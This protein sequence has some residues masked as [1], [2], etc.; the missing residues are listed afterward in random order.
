MI[1]EKD[2]KI[3]NLLWKNRRTMAWIALISIMIVTILCFFVVSVE[4]LDKL[5]SVVT[6]FYTTMASVVGAYM[7]L[8]T[9]ASIKGASPYVNSSVDDTGYVEDQ[10]P[11]P[12]LKKPQLKKP[13]GPQKS[14]K[15]LRSFE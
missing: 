4:R 2:I 14:K 5:S 10:V 7:G 8:S 9:Y 1:E 11:T 12:Q 3:D 13:Q 6:W 15:S